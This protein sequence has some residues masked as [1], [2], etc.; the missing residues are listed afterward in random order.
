MSEPERTPDGRYIVVNGRRWRASDPGIPPKL[1]QELVDELMAARRLVRTD[2]EH[3]RP[4]VQ[5][6]KIALGERG[7]LP[8]SS[9]RCVGAALAMYSRILCLIEAADYDVFSTRH[10]VSAARKSAIAGAVVVTGRARTAAPVAPSSSAVANEP[11]VT[12]SAS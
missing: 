1:R 2:A 11:A 6:A 12:S 4:R 9:R 7:Y 10:R 5:A 3:A 8:A